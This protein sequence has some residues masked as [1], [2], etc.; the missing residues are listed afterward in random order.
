M[1]L[2]QYRIT[3]WQDATWMN[4]YIAQMGENKFWH[5][6]N[7]LDKELNKLN[8]GQSIRIEDWCK[9]ENFDLFI[10]MACCYISE[11][12][13]C[14]CFSTDFKTIKKQFD[15]REMEK[16]LALLRKNR[17]LQNAG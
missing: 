17:Q 14:Y 11:S 9:P 13:G 4:D 7:L 8:V 6:R 2:S 5:Y 1:D 12:Q 10:K 15:A 16:T 3:N